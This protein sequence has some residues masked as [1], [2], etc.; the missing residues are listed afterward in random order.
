VARSFPATSDC[1]PLPSPL[2]FVAFAGGVRVWPMASQLIRGFFWAEEVAVP[3]VSFE[4]PGDPVGAYAEAG[5]TPI[6][7]TGYDGAHRLGWHETSVD[8]WRIM[9]TCTT[10][11]QQR[12][13]VTAP[14][15]IDRATRRRLV[16]AGL[17]PAPNI[18][19]IDLRRPTE[20]EGHPGPGSP[21]EWSH[22]WIVDGHW[23][24]QWH[25]AE[26]KHQPVW[27][28]PHVKG[29]EDKPLV[30]GERVYRWSR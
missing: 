22:R 28:A 18:R 23:R 15:E 27:I 2:G 12:I 1:L 10:M 4:G 17:P 20:R 3:L 9:A 8:L 21:V 19:L 14:V 16:R 26:K 29:P 5:I 24:N 11:M 30:V 25:P 7:L 13:A 6:P